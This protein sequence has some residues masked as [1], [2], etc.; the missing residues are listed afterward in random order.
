MGLGRST[1]LVR[2]M[3]ASASPLTTGRSWRRWKLSD[4]GFGDEVGV[5]GATFCESCYMICFHF[6][7]FFYVANKTKSMQRLKQS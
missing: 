3:G 4:L 1:L 5:V 7:S 2:R 6:A